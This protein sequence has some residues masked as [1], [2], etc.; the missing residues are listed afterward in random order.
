MESGG[1]LPATVGKKGKQGTASMGA[2]GMRGGAQP[3]AVPAATPTVDEPTPGWSGMMCQCM[4]MKHDLVTNCTSCGKIACVVEGGFGCSFCGSALPVTGRE[5]RKVGGGG[6]Q[7]CSEGGGGAQQS[8]ALR[9]AL[10]RKDKLLLF[11]RTSA[12]RTRVLDDQGDYFTSHNW[13]SQKEREKGETEEK[14]RREDAALQRGARRQVKLSIDIMGRRVIETQGEGGEE[15]KQDGGQEAAVEEVPVNLGSTGRSPGAGGN[16][17]VGMGE[18][19]DLTVATEEVSTGTEA[20]ED[21][22]PSLE[23]TGLRGRAKEVYDVMRVNLEKRGRRRADGKGKNGKSG[24]TIAES[25][26]VSLWRVQHDV[27]PEDVDLP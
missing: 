6:I 2:G 1:A 17:G 21:Q 14:A 4:A 3:A 5:P 22:R 11:D 8:E 7:G 24:R 18:A 10:V 9:E 23:N 27:T 16:S 19:V 20:R 15:G 12:S 25:S 13:L 26:R